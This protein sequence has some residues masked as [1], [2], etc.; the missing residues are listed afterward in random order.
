MSEPNSGGSEALESGGG[1][2]VFATRGLPFWIEDWPGLGCPP[3][4]QVPL[5]RS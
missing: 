3:A 2:H 5:S 4:S 1:E